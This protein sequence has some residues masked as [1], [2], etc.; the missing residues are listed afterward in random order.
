MTSKHI[1][2]LLLM[3]LLAVTLAACGDDEPT[4]TAA[5][6]AQSVAATDTPAPPTNTP[7][8][9]TATP[10]PAAAT[11]TPTPAA[12][13]SNSFA[14]PDAVLNSYRTRGQFLITTTRQ[15]ATTAVQEMAL[16]GAFVRTDSAY[17]SDESF[18]MTIKEDESVESVAIYKIGEWVSARSQEDEWITVGRDNAGL[19]TAMSDL[20][21]G[22]VDQFVL[23][24]DD[25]QN[26][27]EE[28]VGGQPATHYRIDDID[29]FQ[30]M[31]Q[32]VPDSQ[33]VIESVTMDVWVAKEGNYILKYSI[34]SEVSNVK[35]TDASG[36]E[37]TVIQTVN[38]SY[39]IHDVNGDITIELPADA[40]QPGVVVIPGFAEGAF[41]L[42]EGGTLAANMIGMPEITSQLSQDELVQFYTD[43]FAALG[44]TFAGD[45]GFYEVKK[46][47]VSFSMFIDVGENGKGRAQI[48]AEQ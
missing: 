24:Q 28:S 4:P 20:F 36:A 33:E 26:L 1:L 13:A 40:P 45:F 18:L 19:F 44:W 21:T 8:P 5:L 32:M 31:A 2:T 11:N 3:A 14:A 48:F 46:G 29:I 10:L 22:F 23:E 38:W 30:R 39:E 42:P 34:Q 16:E 35:E 9:P 7:L 6:E 25:A 47:D 12:S 17:G 15:D 43:A 41:P 37:V 27:G